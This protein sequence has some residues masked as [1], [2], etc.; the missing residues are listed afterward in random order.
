MERNDESDRFKPL[1][2]HLSKEIEAHTNSMIQFRTR[3]TFTMFVGPFILLGAFLI[4]TKDVIDKIEMNLMAIVALVFLG[5]FWMILGFLAGKFEEH[6]WNQCNKWR[7]LIVQ[8]Q[9]KIELPVMEHDVVYEHEVKH[10][11]LLSHAILLLAFAATV[12]ALFTLTRHASAPSQT[13]PRQTEQVLPQ[14]STV[15][16]Q[17]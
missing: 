1:I 17:R 9:T 10:A 12:V 5:G 13:Y 3:I 6:I 8:L 4:A 2:E 16:S 14:D 15:S 7:R 11:Y